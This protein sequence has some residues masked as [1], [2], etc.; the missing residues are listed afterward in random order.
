MCL[1]GAVV[2]GNGTSA[3][4]SLTVR[5]SVKFEV[6]DRSLMRL[7]LLG[8]QLDPGHGRHLRPPN[9]WRQRMLRRPAGRS[10]S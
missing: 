1:M 5:S 7:G 8:A 4:L 10:L 3:D 6:L 9:S 2:S